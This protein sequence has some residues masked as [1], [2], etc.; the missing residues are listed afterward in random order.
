MHP[1]LLCFYPSSVGVYKTIILVPLVYILVI[2]II[3][4]DHSANI[5]TNTAENNDVIILSESEGKQDGKDVEIIEAVE[6]LHP[7]II[8]VRRRSKL[9]E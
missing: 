9:Q 2:V 6:D 7:D 1:K 5:D 8:F 3:A 4:N